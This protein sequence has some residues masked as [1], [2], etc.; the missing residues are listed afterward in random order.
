MNTTTTA[1][2]TIETGP[3]AA[4]AAAS[5]VRSCA[6]TPVNLLALALN[7]EA[8]A[9]REDD[10]AKALT[11]LEAAEALRELADLRATAAL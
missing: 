10:E 6:V 5:P 2:T 7:L 8:I 4:G 11:C 3:N 9:E 1:T